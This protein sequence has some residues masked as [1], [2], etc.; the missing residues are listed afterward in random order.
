[1]FNNPSY[2]EIKDM[3]AQGKKPMMFYH[4]SKEE[5]LNKDL[6]GINS[7]LNTVSKVGKGAKQSLVITCNGYDDVT[8]ELYEI[9]EVREFVEHMFNRHPHLLYYIANQLEAEHWLMCSIADEL[10]SVYQGELYTGN[11]LLE[12]FGLD[13][14]AVPKVHVHL[15]FKGSRF[16]SILK[17]MIKHGKVNKDA[18]G[19]KKLALEYAIKFDNFDRTLQEL[20]ISEE[21]AKELLS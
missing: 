17:A 4:I 10:N 7:L 11:Q 12:K 1:M 9:K 2:K 20:N 8:D 14:N 5:I 3:I 15:T 16:T 6:R 18:R 19:G 21:E 13:P